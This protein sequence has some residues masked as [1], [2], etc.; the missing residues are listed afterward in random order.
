ML[1]NQFKVILKFFESLQVTILD[2]FW[3]R[4]LQ[5]PYLPEVNE[6]SSD[7]YFE[8]K[9]FFEKLHGSFS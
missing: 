8:K 4:K 2:N 6:R 3:L 1:S 9:S 7:Q 5:T